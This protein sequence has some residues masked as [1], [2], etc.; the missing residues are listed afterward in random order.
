MWLKLFNFEL[1]YRL[2][3]PETYVFF[4]VLFL[5]SIVGVDFI[6]QGVEIG[7]MKGNAPLVLAKTMGALTALF[8][9]MVSMIMGVPVL[10]DYQY[11]T[12]ALLFVNPISKRAYLLGRFLGSFTVLL[13]IFSGMPL[14]MLLGSQM[15]WHQVAD[16]L[17]FAVWPYL[18]SFVVVVLPTLFFGAC[19]FFVTGM[20]SK[21]LLVV[22]TQGVVL[23]VIFLLTKAITDPYWQGVFDPFSLT[24]LTQFAKSWTAAQRNARGIGFNG[25]MLHNKL[26][27][28]FLGLT[29]LGYGYRKFSFS[30]LVKTQGKKKKTAI[31]PSDDTRAIPRAKQRFSLKAEGQRLFELVKFYSLSLLKEASFW[32]IVGCGLVI[33]GINSV[34]LGTVYG[35][36]SYPAT[37][38]IIAELQE[39]SLYFF[40]ILLL[41][42]SGELFWKERTNIQFVLNDATPIANGSVV[43]AKLLALQLV[44]VGLMVV[45]ILAGVLFQA[46]NGYYQCDLGVY[47]TGFFVEILPFLT[48]YSCMAFLFQ[49]IAKNRFVGIFLTLIFFIA[50]IGS[51]FLGFN[52]SLYKFGGKPLGSYSE[53]NGYG[54]FLA[55]YLWTKT[56]WA[57]FAA[58]V[59]V[60]ASLLMQR[61]MGSSLKQ[62]FQNLKRQS[63]PAVRKL[64][65]TLLVLLVLCGGYIFYNTNVLNTYWTAGEEQDFRAAYEQTLKPMEYHP[66]PKITAAELHVELYPESRS[67]TVKGSY[68]LTNL[69]DA[70]ITTIAIQ[71]RIASHLQLSEVRFEGGA[72]ADSTHARFGYIDY[73]LQQALQPNQTVQFDFVQTFNP[74]GFEEGGQDT[75]MVDNGSFIHN[76]EFPTLGYNR[77]YE[78]QDPNEREVMGLAP[79]QR[80]AQIDDIHEM[81]NARSGSDSDGLLLDITIGTKDGQTALAPGTL[82]RQWSSNGRSYFRYQSTEPIVNFYTIVSAEYEVLKD[83]WKSSSE[84]ENAVDLEIYH[85]PSHTYNLDRM[86]KAMKASLTYFSDNFSPYQYDQLRIMEV[87]RYADFAQSLPNTI[88]FS[89]GLGFVLDIDDRNDVDMVFFITAHEI[90]HQWFGMQLEAAH[91]QG[92]YFVLETLAQYG[93]L[94]VLKAHYPEEKV[95]QFFEMQEEIYERERKKGKMEASLAL[96]ENQDFVYYNKGVL[97]MNELSELIGEARINKALKRFIADWR[98]YEGTKKTQSDRYASSRELLDYLRAETPE[99][100]Q[101]VLHRLFETVE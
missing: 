99:A 96:V 56:Y 44:Y 76:T 69:T 88:P 34:N 36:D 47:F 16:M 25:I 35:V 94:M 39:N 79:R 60:L 84:A 28:F 6:F 1:N 19:L 101:E 32:A 10:R 3:R 78:L 2:K 64:G 98:S 15:P 17:P 62:R 41:F 61:G 81:I 91:V 45:L 29:V 75:K 80:K 9:I 59:V 63:T 66:Q 90:A 38:F 43:V 37:H 68:S 85:H 23:F 82:Q 24:T 95:Q 86:Q 65:A 83:N 57:V 30:T 67:Y 89:E 72:E 55:P 97:A 54:H 14:G 18:Q 71:Q 46:L 13:L 27:W 58:L 73:T 21:K 5:F 49:A 70:P 22:Y 12:E 52:H 74:K 8:M 31:E 33:I 11:E 7:L 4:G 20:L 93:A 87:P 100:H 42:Y 51:E 40:I 53:M 48:L 77:K 92:Q 26:F 50:N